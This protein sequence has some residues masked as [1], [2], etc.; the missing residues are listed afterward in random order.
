MV[1]AANVLVLMFHH[2]K[3]R[4]NKRKKSS[5]IEYFNATLKRKKK[6]LCRQ[7]GSILIHLEKVVRR[8]PF[9]ISTRIRY[10]L[11]SRSMQKILKN[12]RN[13]ATYKLE[14]SVNLFLSESSFFRKL[15]NISSR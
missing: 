14:I 8:A 2:R 5:R 10:R 12:C 13:Q 7:L 3:I 6:V 4:E 1:A 9:A 11:Y 15:E